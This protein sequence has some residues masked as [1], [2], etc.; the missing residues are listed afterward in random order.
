MR[1][2][3][4]DPGDSDS[5][6]SLAFLGTILFLVAPATVLGLVPFW[7]SGWRVQPAFLGLGALRVI[8]GILLAGGVAVL[9]DSYFRLALQGLGTPAPVFPTRRLVV[10][11]LFRYVRNPIYV[12]LVTGIIGQALML[13]SLPVLAYGLFV[14]LAFH[15]FVLIHEEPRLRKK[16]GGQYEDFCT[17]VPRW[18]PRVRPWRGDAM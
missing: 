13:G 4:V 11:G 10:T 2:Q 8:G 9:L 7:L 14:W 5:R 3:T 16:F 17:H 6:R 1:S 18:L 15:G 12:A